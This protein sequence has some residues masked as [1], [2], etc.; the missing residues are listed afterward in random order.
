MTGS[1]VKQVS[2]ETSPDN[3]R[4]SLLIN[5]ISNWA[6]FGVSL[7]IGFLLTPYII[8]HLGTKNYGVWTLVLS[9]V[10]YYGLLRLGVGNGII[11]Y[12]PYYRGLDDQI[13]VRET[14]STATAI[15]MLA[16]LAIFTISLFMA[17]SIAAFFKG[18]KELAALVR[19]LGFASAVECLAHVL[20]SCVRA[21]EKW[22]TAN[23][24]S[25]AVRVFQALGFVIFLYFGYGIVEMSYVVVAA[26]VFSTLLALYLF[27]RYCRLI[28]LRASL[29]KLTRAKLLVSFGLITTIG[30]IGYN[31]RLAGHNLII[32]KLLS[33]E[34]VAVYAIAVVLMRNI[35]LLA[36][37]PTRVF[38]PRF[39]HL[40]AEKKLQELTTLFLTTTRFCAALA[41]GAIL[42]IFTLG[43]N[44]IH[45]WVGPVFE[46]VCPALMI[47]AVGYLIETSLGSMIPLLGCTGHEKA[48]AIIG[49]A[50]TILGFGLSIL[51]I[52][53]MQLVGVALGFL[54]S[55]LIINGLVGSWFVCRFLNIR[56]MRDYLQCLLRPWLILVVLTFIT[57]SVKPAKFVEGW[58]TLVLLGLALGTA[59]AICTYFITFNPDEKEKVKNIAGRCLAYFRSL[60]GITAKERNI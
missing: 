39:A 17:E 35:R 28:S 11:R 54:I 2:P 29:V 16:G 60:F 57:Y 45:L 4:P 24:A 47:L 31:M 19:I 33:L 23:L 50:D 56:L 59:Y 12:V 22:L 3:A 26:T 5:V 42:M 40:Y 1:Q 18:G 55:S 30:N 15:F 8:A 20:D 48:Q 10:G 44:F 13:A 46:S 9:F 41:S 43:P 53:S 21:Y 25:I 36:V 34:T 6:P 51:L 52:K 7:L 27:G 38:W 37:T 49:V 32:G 14:I 58:I